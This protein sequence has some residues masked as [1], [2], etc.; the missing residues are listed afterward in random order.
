MRQQ[1]DFIGHDPRAAIRELVFHVFA[2]RF[3]LNTFMNFFHDDAVMHIVGRVADYPFSGDY[4]G[5]SAIRAVLE[6]MDS[7]VEQT[8]GEILNLLIEDDRIAIRRANALRHYGTAAR[9]NLMVS[10]LIRFQDSK[11]TELHEY[12]DTTWHERLAGGD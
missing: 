7:E 11:I 3:D 5:R 10:D 9:M 4:V 8:Q 6:R 12:I 2:T 1:P